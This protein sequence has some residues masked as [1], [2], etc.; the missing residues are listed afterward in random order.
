MAGPY[1]EAWHRIVGEE[2][3]DDIHDRT[4]YS[5]REIIQEHLEFVSGFPDW[6][7]MPRYERMEVWRDYLDVM[8]MGNTDHMTR[9][10]FFESIGLDPRD[11][12]WEGWR[13]A[14]GYSR[15]AA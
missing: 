4:G 14:M 8:V 15:N 9:N 2:F 10:E 7:N 6:D 13:E 1:D 11:F 5:E 12:D 3:T